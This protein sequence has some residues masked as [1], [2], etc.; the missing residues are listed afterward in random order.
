M[1][2]EQRLNTCKKILEILRS[3]RLKNIICQNGDLIPI[4][5]IGELYLTRRK[6]YQK[7]K[8]N[9]TS[10]DA[11]AENLMIMDSYTLLF[12]MLP[13]I[14]NYTQKQQNAFINYFTKGNGKDLFLPAQHQ[15]IMKELA[16]SN[17]NKWIALSCILTPHEIQKGVQRLP[18]NLQKVFFKAFKEQVK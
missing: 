2:N 10:P 5:P 17:L 15:S 18:L 12:D 6:I 4:T 16:E 8:E 14:K 7:R 1:T 9:K 11:R 13:L 3:V